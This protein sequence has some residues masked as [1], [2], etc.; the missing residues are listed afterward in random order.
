MAH[1]GP[2]H[3]SPGN[4]GAGLPVQEKLFLPNAEGPMPRLSSPGPKEEP[5]QEGAE[6]HAQPWEH[7]HSR[8]PRLVGPWWLQPHVPGDKALCDNPDP[9]VLRTMQK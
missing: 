5:A 9:A 2:A 8:T 7:E 6:H 1:P 3:S 4:K